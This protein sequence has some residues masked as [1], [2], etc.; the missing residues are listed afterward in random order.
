[1]YIYIYIYVYICMYIGLTCFLC[2]FLLQLAM[3]VFDALDSA[4]PEL[5]YA[6]AKYL[7]STDAQTAAINLLRQVQ[8]ELDMRM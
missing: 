7:W 2:F 6:Y 5:V 3:G 4:A 8:F 1:M